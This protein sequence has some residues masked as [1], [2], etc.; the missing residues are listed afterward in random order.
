MVSRGS[1]Y[2]ID[3]TLIHVFIVEAIF[4]MTDTELEELV[5]FDKFESVSYYL[6]GLEYII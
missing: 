1:S 3:E 5:N 4:P 6:T 2:E